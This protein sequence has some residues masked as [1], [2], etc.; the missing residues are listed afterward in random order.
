[1]GPE[2]RGVLRFAALQE[3]QQYSA[4]LSSDSAAARG[5][6]LQDCR[7]LQHEEWPS[8]A[9]SVDGGRGAAQTS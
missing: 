8:M 1:M 3:L 9:A 6:A 7:T 2:E 4:A 5:R